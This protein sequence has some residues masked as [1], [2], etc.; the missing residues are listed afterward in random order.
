[1][2]VVAW[3]RSLA[4]PGVPPVLVA[5]LLLLGGALVLGILLAALRRRGRGAAAPSP[6]RLRR[7]ARRALRRGDYLEAGRLFLECGE[8]ASAAA[9]YEQG[10]AFLEAGRIWEAEGQP[11]KAARAFELGGESGRAAE[12]FLRLGQAARAGALYQRD[13]QDTRAAEAFAKAGDLSRA[14]DLFARCE[15]FGRA[16]EILLALGRAAEA[17]DLLERD[18]ARRRAASEVGRDATAL[19]GAARRCAGAHIAAGRPARAA[20][21]LRAQGLEMDAAEQYCEAGEWET[22]LELFLRHRAFDRAA[23]LCRRLGKSAELFR[24]EGERH[25]AL[26]QEA[27]A[28]RAFEAAGIW[29]RAT[30]AYQ[31]AG[32]F[33]KAAEMAAAY[34][35][36]ERAAE[37]FAAAGRPG[38]AGATMERLG[39]GPEAAR[40]YQEAGRL[41]DAA[42]VLLGAG[43]GFAAGALYRKLGAAE[44]AVRAFQQVTPEAAHYLDAT[45]ALGDLFLARDLIGPAR[46]KYER[47]LSLRSSGPTFLHATYRLARIHD[48]QG[49]SVEAARLLDRVV[50]E[51]FDYLDARERLLSLRRAPAPPPPASSAEE[52]TRLIAPMAPSRYRVLRELGRGGMGIVFE[53]E[54]EVLKRRVAYKVLSE[55][56][57]Q[58]AK[59]VDEFLR[60]ARIAASLKHPNIVTVYDAG[61]EGDRVYI[62]MELVEGR[63]VDHLLDAAAGPLPLSQGVEIAR[64]ACQGLMHA[65]AERVVHRDVKPANMMLTS[66]G[67]IKLMDFGLAVVSRATAKV[68]SI[69]GTP[70]YMAP[71]QILGTPASPAADQYALGCSLYHMLTG[72]PPFVEGDVLYHHIHTEPAGPRERNPAVPL[73]LS[74]IVLRTMRKL[75][76]DRFPTI[77]ALLAAVEECL[78][79]VRTGPF[80]PPESR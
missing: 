33:A 5:A 54:D 75:P 36:L 67:L 65:H 37:M 21:V 74:A 18:L 42:R 34:G 14:A 2:R 6:V 31:R 27:E 22:G 61:Q 50:A 73:W 39:R 38:E 7:A 60:E 79:S 69:R 30:D 13:G 9:A 78:Q 12:L 4:I 23:D 59:A 25:A 80:L 29:W 26:G 49:N 41:A 66:G 48:R 3:S 19:E 35:D 51:R 17:A 11:A 56:L 76:A 40:Y 68:T 47:A 55:A 53:A 52:S 15:A 24:V 62:A 44:E 32:D 71:E 77:A 46:E 20:A 64:Q 10:Q 1:M 8:A 43:D 57:R 16:G 63:S 58:D 28:G 70:F 45:V 72:R